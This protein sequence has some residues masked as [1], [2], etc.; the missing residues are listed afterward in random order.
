MK[1]AVEIKIQT[2]QGEEEGY[3]PGENE[4]G[5]N[6]LLY[7]ELESWTLLTSLCGSKCKQFQLLHSVVAYLQLSRKSN[8]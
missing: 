3:V 5:T 8:K 1:A 6:L 4:R 7:N 2:R